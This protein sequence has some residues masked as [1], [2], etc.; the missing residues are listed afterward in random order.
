VDSG[1]IAEL[2]RTLASAGTFVYASCYPLVAFLG[3]MAFGQGL[4]GDFLFSRMQV[5]IAPTLGIPLM[6]LVGIITVVTMGPPNALKPTQIAFA[7]SLAN[8]KGR[9]GEIFR[10]CLPWVLLQL[11]VTAV[12]SVFLVYWWK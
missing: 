8:V 7:S 12:L 6:V 11:V 5:S 1:Q 10:I 2:G 3:G 4:P 9:D